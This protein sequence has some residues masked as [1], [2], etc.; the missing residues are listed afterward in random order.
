MT[1]I[2]IRAVTLTLT[3]LH[4]YTCKFIPG[5]YLTIAHLRGLASWIQPGDGVNLTIRRE[6]YLAGCLTLAEAAG[7]IHHQSGF[8]MVTPDIYSWLKATPAAQIKHLLQPLI[9]ESGWRQIVRLSGLQGAIPDHLSLY[10]RQQ[11]LRQANPEPTEWQPASWHKVTTKGW[12]LCLPETLSPYL[13][14]HLNQLGEWQPGKPLC[15]TSLTIAQA[16]A[17]GYGLATVRTLLRQATGQPLPKIVESTVTEWFTHLGGVKVRAVHL[18]TTKQGDQ[19]AQILQNRRLRKHIQ[20]VIGPRQAITRA[21]II[22]SLQRWLAQQG[23]LLST[24][25]SAATIKPGHKSHEPAVDHTWLALRVLS[26]LGELIPLPVPVPQVNQ[27]LASLSLSEERLSELEGVAQ[28]LLAGLHQAIR[29]RDAFFP[30]NDPTNV[31]L[32]SQ[33]QA[34]IADEYDVEIS[35]QSLVDKQ[36]YPRIVSPLWLDEKGELFY[37]HAYCHLA[38]AERVFRLDR[39]HALKQI[40]EYG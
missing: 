22:P 26:G 13:W 32:L 33:L 14:F 20:E 1:P 29:G 25:K 30:A 10:W 5:R 37:L 21:T 15:C 40:D 35:Y 28:E 11:L 31:V 27:T 23:V 39:I 18:L 36:P 8:W 24:I 38:E 9:N 12:C 19:L 16:A 17:K 7:L 3:Y 6:P 34:A 2:T 4:Y